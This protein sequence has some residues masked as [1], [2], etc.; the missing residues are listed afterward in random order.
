MSSVVAT[1]NPRFGRLEFASEGFRQI[2]KSPGMPSGKVSLSGQLEGAKLTT[3]DSALP[4]Y[5]DKSRKPTD[6][7][8]GSPRA[9]VPTGRFG[10]ETLVVL[11]RQI[12]TGFNPISQASWSYRNSRLPGMRDINR[13]LFRTAVIV[14]VGLSRESLLQLRFYSVCDVP[15]NRKRQGILRIVVE[16]RELIGFRVD[17]LAVDRVFQ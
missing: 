15:G 5:R 14:L 4:G 2:E 9:Y 6:C 10:G 11:V 1:V 7:T 12:D 3:E 16:D 8:A 13:S 17:Q